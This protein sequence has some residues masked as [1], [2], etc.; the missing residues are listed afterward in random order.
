[1]PNVGNK[2][3]GCKTSLIKT[4]AR[5]VT[6]WLETVNAGRFYETKQSKGLQDLINLRSKRSEY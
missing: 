1:M 4:T 5:K 2:Q 6:V 3:K